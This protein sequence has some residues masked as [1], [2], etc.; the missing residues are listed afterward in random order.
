MLRV[1]SA[2]CLIRSGHPQ[3]DRFSLKFSAK[4]RALVVLACLSASPVL[5]TTYYVSLNGSDSN[6]G[7]NSAS[8][9]GSVAKIDATVF[10]PGDQ[11]LFQYGSTWN[12]SLTATSN[13]TTT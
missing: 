7:T 12:A 1:L 8:P 3:P 9:W 10:K 13:G 4:K 5:G 11:I 2:G 6:I